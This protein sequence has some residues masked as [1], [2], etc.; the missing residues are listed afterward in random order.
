MKHYNLTLEQIVV[1]LS[2]GGPEGPPSTP[3]PSSGNKGGGTT[4]NKGGGDKTGGDKTGGEN[5]PTEKPKQTSW[6][7][8]ITAA[9]PDIKRWINTAV[10]FFETVAPMTTDFDINEATVASKI[11]KYLGATGNEGIKMCTYTDWIIRLA[12]PSSQSSKYAMKH[13]RQYE[14]VLSQNGVKGTTLQYLRSIPKHPSFI[15]LNSLVNPASKLGDW[16]G[17]DDINDTYGKKIR[18][19]LRLDNKFVFKLDND[20][21]PI[22]SEFKKA[23]DPSTRNAI[24]LTLYKNGNFGTPK[25]QFK[26]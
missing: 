26:I 24:V 20:G 2:G 9:S 14:Y 13:K 19:S 10:L 21:N 3:K 1:D 25:P 8:K 11:S 23:S 5:K 18:N 16:L 12:N 22:S 6:D 7:K 15:T 17:T 4:I